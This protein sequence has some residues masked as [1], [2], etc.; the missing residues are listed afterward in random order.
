M[1]IWGSESSLLSVFEYWRVPAKNTANVRIMTF[2]CTSS[3]GPGWSCGWWVSEGMSYRQQHT[4]LSSAVPLPLLFQFRCSHPLPSGSPTATATPSVTGS[5]SPTVTGN[6]TGVLRRVGGPVGAWDVEQGVWGW[7]GAQRGGGGGG[8]AGGGVRGEGAPWTAPLRRDWARALGITFG[9]E[10]S[11][12]SVVGTAHKTNADFCGPPRRVPKGPCS[13][14]RSL[15]VERPPR[16][17]REALVGRFG[18][19]RGLQWAGG[20]SIDPPL[21]PPH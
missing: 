10:F 11:G 8:G 20:C 17:R 13:L 3:Q 12:P 4:S 5:P 19:K 6:C 2:H 9:A 14:L 18:G 15:R 21:P 1:S 7:N 16:P